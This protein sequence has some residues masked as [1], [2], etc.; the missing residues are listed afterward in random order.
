MIPIYY[1]DKVNA[2]MMAIAIF[3]ILFAP[4]AFLPYLPVASFA[5]NTSFHILFGLQI[6]AIALIMVTTAVQCR[7][8]IFE[9]PVY[10][11]AAPLSGALISLSFMSAI[12]D[13]KKKG[14]VSWRDRKYIISKTQNP[15]S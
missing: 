8:A 13:A 2:Y 7:L 12:A 5:G 9:S 15:V 10:A 3:F 11:F 14:A 6:S 1:Q 4:F